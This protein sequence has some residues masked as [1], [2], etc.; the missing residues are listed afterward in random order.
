LE[1]QGTI[2]H[3]AFALQ[4]RHHLCTEGSEVH[5]RPSTCARAASV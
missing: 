4:Q 1:L 3:T 2:R 5:Q